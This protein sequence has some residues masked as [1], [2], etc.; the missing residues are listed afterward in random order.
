MQINQV[1]V[2][3]LLVATKEEAE[4]A[5][6]EILDGEKTFE[7]EA[8]EVSQCPSK[9]EGGDLGYFGKGQMVP[10]FEQ[11]AFE[12]AEKKSEKSEDLISVPVQTQFG[13]H[14]IKVTGKK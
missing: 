14:L 13:Y 9:S 2:S 3:H 1:K 8:A 11:A 10:E 6:Q 5:R 4:K 7:Q 12:L